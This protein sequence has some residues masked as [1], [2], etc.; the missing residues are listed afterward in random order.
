MTKST[1]EDKELFFSKLVE[2]ERQD[3]DLWQDQADDDEDE[4]TIAKSIMNEIIEETEG[5][6]ASSTITEN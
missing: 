5:S 3:I 6:P 1:Q 4:N 2:V